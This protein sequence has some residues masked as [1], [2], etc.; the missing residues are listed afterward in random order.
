MMVP[1]RFARRTIVFSRATA[2]GIKI[3]NR[4][5]QHNAWILSVLGLGT[6]VGKPAPPPEKIIYNEIGNAWEPF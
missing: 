1:A 3:G 2:G 5:N 4:V 6:K